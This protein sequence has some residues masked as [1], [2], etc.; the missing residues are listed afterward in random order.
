MGL[1]DP[2]KRLD[3]W[4]A[5]LLDRCKLKDKKGRTVG[6]T[7]GVMGIVER[8]GYVSPGYSIYVEK[9]KHFQALG[10]V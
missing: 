2:K 6:R 4:P 7:V 8:D 10:N 1:R 9:P 5:G 3:E